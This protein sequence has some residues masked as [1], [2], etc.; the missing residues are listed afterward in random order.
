MRPSVREPAAGGAGH[1]PGA[2][3]GVDG[4]GRTSTTRRVPLANPVWDTE[5]RMLVLK[6]RPLPSYG[7]AIQMQVMQLLAV[8]NL[9][10]GVLK[11]FLMRSLCT[12]ADGLEVRRPRTPCKQPGSAQA[13]GVTAGGGAQ[14]AV[15]ASGKAPRGGQLCSYQCRVQR[16]QP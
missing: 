14:K 2:P 5:M 1:I 13:M 9:E 6:V 7:R 3:A 11:F 10:N 8:C 16:S 15:A 4:G 12:A